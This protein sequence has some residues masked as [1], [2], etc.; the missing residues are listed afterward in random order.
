M[1]VRQREEIQTLPSENGRSCRERAICPGSAAP[2]RLWRTCPQRVA[3]SP[4][5]VGRGGP[6]SA[7]A[8]RAQ[9]RTVSRLPF[10]FYALAFFTF[11]A[12]FFARNAAHRFRCAAAMRLRAAALILRMGVAADFS[13]AA[14]LAVAG[15]CPLWYAA[16]RFRCAAAMR[17]R[18]AALMFRRRSAGGRS[19]TGNTSCSSCSAGRPSCRCITAILPEIS[20]SRCS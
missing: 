7:I 12:P 19:V 18:P 15:A 20:A 2:T 5:P 10:F 9:A 14:F 4:N 13:A 3:T 6:S 1:L 17:L 16:H 8:S 11:G